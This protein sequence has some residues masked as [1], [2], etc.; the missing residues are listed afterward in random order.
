M[1]LVTRVEEAGYGATFVCRA[2]LIP[3]IGARDEEI[4]K[5]LSEAFRRGGQQ[6]VR[7]LWRNRIPDARG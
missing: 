6:N 4:G 7:S 5:G 2:A 1:P 3:R